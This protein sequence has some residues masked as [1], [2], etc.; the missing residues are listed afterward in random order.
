MKLFTLILGTSLL[1]S[2]MIISLKAQTTLFVKEK[3]GP[4]SAY[5]L[6]QTRKISFSG[7]NMTITKTN[8]AEQTYTLGDI[9]FFSFK[10]YFL[11]IPDP[12][13]DGNNA[14]RLY[15]NPANSILKIEYTGQ[16]ATGY[17]LEI[18]DLQ[19]RLLQKYY[20]Q[21]G[22]TGIDVANLKAGIYLCRLKDSSKEVIGKFIKN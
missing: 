3:S 18:L 22:R 12:G 15:P 8:A 7:N 5:A 4:Q 11:G 2:S 1:F 6:S 16:I 14:I 19:G 17:P 20:L 10:N 21:N 9:R 13:S